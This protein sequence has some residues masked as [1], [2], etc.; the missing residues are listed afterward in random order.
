MKEFGWGGVNGL[1]GGAFFL[2]SALSFG[3]QENITAFLS[4]LA[5]TSYSVGPFN[6]SIALILSVITVVTS[7]GVNSFGKGA[8]SDAN[9]WASSALIILFG[10]MALPSFDAWAS[11]G[12]AGAG[13]FL[14]T[15]A[16]YSVLGGVGGDSDSSD[17]S[18]PSITDTI[19]GGLSR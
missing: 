4:T 7:A 15:V 18:V 13:L 3:L 2:M 17:S 16:A 12:N 6:L 11:S 14:F 5:T 1:A 10:L 9:Q 19:K 8:N